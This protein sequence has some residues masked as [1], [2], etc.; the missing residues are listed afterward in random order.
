M[1]ARPL[2]DAAA[3]AFPL[4]SDLS[5]RPVT[6]IDEAELRVE[7]A[8]E[9]DRRLQFYP[10]RVLKQMMR[11]DEAH[12]FIAIWRALID[13]A[14]DGNRAYTFDWE[15]RVR[16]LRRELALRRAA[17]PRWVA[18][19]SNPLTADEAASR[20]ERLDALHAHYWLGLR[21]FAAPG[22]DATPARLSWAAAH[23]AGLAEDA[24][25]ARAAMG[26]VDGQ[27]D[28]RRTASH[29]HG[30]AALIDHVAGGAPWYRIATTDQLATL[31]TTTAQARAQALADLDAGA[32]L[33]AQFELATAI[34]DLIG[35]L[36]NHTW[37]AE[38]E[39]EQPRIAA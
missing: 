13:D 22:I 15:T 7:L 17:Y 21:G 12:R 24:A 9:L 11:Q 16:E 36:H 26:D 5:R 10:G 38:R 39:P 29:W 27:I 19:P 20:L 34:D 25:A 31:A 32:I 4:A 37:R 14:A 30:I 33:P 6:A 28:H 23:R 8:A 3:R 18:S 35:G 2:T 1:G